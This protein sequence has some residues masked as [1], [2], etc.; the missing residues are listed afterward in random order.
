M[1]LGSVLAMGSMYKDPIPGD[2]LGAYAPIWVL[3]GVLISECI[4][5]YKRKGGETGWMTKQ[6]KKP[7]MH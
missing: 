7:N 1:K 6:L 4:P 3:M 2:L 5:K